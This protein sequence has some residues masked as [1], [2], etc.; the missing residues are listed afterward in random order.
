MICYQSRK[1]F[2]LVSSTQTNKV[3]ANSKSRNAFT[4][5]DLIVTIKF[6]KTD[7]LENSVLKFWKKSKVFHTTVSVE[8]I[9]SLILGKVFLCHCDYFKVRLNYAT[10]H[11]HPPPPTTSQNISTTTHHFP[12]T[13]PPPRKSQNIFIYNL[14]LALQYCFP[15]RGFCVTKFWSVRFSSSKFLLIFRSSHRRC[16]V[17][18]GVI[19]HFAVHRKTPVPGDSF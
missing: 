12:K 6:G 18:I 15:W 13:G 19:R 14:L 3:V 5:S 4:I 9:Q 1:C 7:S 2:Y 8:E 11:H 17:R 16:S 10:T